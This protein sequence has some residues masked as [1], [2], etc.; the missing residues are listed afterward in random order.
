MTQAQKKRI[1]AFMNSLLKDYV[2]LN[3]AGYENDAKHV[4]CRYIGMV[5]TVLMLGYQ[6]ENKADGSIRICK[7]A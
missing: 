7:G 1:E 5:E 3:N 4:K 2:A 6:V